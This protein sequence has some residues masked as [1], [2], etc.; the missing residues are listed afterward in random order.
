MKNKR[1]VGIG[2]ISFPIALL[3]IV[4]S[5][6]QINGIT[7]GNLLNTNIPSVII[8]LILFLISI[9]VGRKYSDDLFSK[10]SIILSIIFISLIIILS[11]RIF[12]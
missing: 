1:K 10:T 4:F 3:G 12:I 5:F 6:S 9:F 8:S 2:T 7:L 11:I